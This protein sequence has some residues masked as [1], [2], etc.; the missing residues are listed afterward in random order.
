MR[1]VTCHQGVLEVGELPDPTPGRRHVVLEVRACG[2]CG[3]D[4]HARHHCDDVAE[5]V[6]ASGYD[7]FMRSDQTVVMGHEFCGEVVD[8]G[9]RTSGRLKAGTLAG[10]L[11]MGR[12]G[13]RVHPTGVA[14]PA[15]RRG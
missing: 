8:H 5:D 13:G 14:V 1:A 12:R 2:I 15:P 3:S 6:L 4:L 9:P 7:A 10:S 11:P